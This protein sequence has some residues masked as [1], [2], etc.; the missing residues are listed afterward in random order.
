MDKF[1]EEPISLFAQV[2][3]S[4]GVLFATFFALYIGESELF[5]VAVMSC[6]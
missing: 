4:D 3:C 5:R 6:H 1:S 2:N